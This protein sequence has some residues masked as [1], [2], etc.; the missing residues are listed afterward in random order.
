LPDRIADCLVRPRA[1]DR[2]LRSCGE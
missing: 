1:T 2:S